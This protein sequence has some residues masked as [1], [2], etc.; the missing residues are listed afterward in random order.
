MRMLASTCDLPTPIAITDGV[1]PRLLTSD[2]IQLALSSKTFSILLL[3]KTRY[4]FARI[5]GPPPN[6]K[7][8]KTAAIG[9]YTCWR[10]LSFTGSTGVSATPRVCHLDGAGSVPVE[11]GPALISTML[12]GGPPGKA[13]RSRRAAVRGELAARAGSAATLICRQGH[14]EMR[15]RS[16][17]T[18]GTS[19]SRVAGVR[20]AARL[21]ISTCKRST[22]IIQAILRPTAEAARHQRA[23]AVGTS[24]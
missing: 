2:A 22:S 14:R 4:V 1:Q 13:S 8:A 10:F 24:P 15:L 23:V 20:L 7:T 11:A 19:T 9:K 3:W 21:M 5:S 12:A 17:A 6:S 18:P 16:S